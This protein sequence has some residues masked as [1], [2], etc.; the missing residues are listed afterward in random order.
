MAVSRGEGVDE[1]GLESVGVLIL[2]DEDGPEA[3][4]V[5]GCDLRIGQQQFVR[6]GEKVVEVEE[7]TSFLR[8]S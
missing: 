7:F 6:L 4:L 3:A 5:G 1:S 8:P 2:V